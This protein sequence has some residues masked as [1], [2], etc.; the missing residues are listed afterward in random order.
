MANNESG[1]TLG[2]IFGALAGLAI[3]LLYAPKPGIETRG[4]I[5]EKVAEIRNRAVEIADKT[6]EVAEQTE[7]RV[8]ER[9][10]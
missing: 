10:A 9:L 3:G 2:F 1:F 7:R 4:I 8:R 6:R 5:Q